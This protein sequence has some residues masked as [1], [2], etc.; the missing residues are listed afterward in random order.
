M[1]DYISKIFK[2]YFLEDFLEEIFK[3]YFFRRTH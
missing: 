1:N 3:E 2:E